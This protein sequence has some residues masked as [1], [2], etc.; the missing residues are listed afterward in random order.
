MANDNFI[1]LLD[2]SATDPESIDNEGSLE[3]LIPDEDITVEDSQEL[4]GQKD[5]IEG[6]SFTIKVYKKD[7][8]IDSIDIECACGKTAKI[9]LD[10]SEKP[11]DDPLDADLETG[12]LE[13]S[14]SKDQSEMEQVVNET[15][16]EG[17]E[18]NA[19]F[20]EGLPVTSVETEKTGE[21]EKIVEDQAGVDGPNEEQDETP[22]PVKDETQDVVQDET[23]NSVE[24]E[25]SEE[26]K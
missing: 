19:E 16:E 18:E 2:I 11:V 25:S 12:N 21:D 8:V 15:P 17:E 23:Q 3:R 26:Q 1:D 7:N 20:V 24:D 10:Y 13:V 9:Q 5:T 14:V 22:D 4:L 6:E